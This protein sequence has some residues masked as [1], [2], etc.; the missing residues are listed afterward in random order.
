MKQ[1]V[2][3]LDILGT[4]ELVSRDEFSDSHAF[5]FS[6]AVAV[7][8]L[9]F[10]SA[11]FAA[12]S[13]CVIFSVPANSPNDIISIL[14]H[15]FENWLSDGIFVRGGISVGDIRWIDYQS[16]REFRGLKNLSFARVY[17]KALSEAVDIERS[18]G[19][20]ILP[21]A[22]DA[23]ADRLSNRTEDSVLRLSSN[24]LRSFEW[25]NLDAWIRTMD[26]YL[27]YAE[28]VQARRHI[29]ATKRVLEI[30]KL[31]NTEQGGKGVDGKKLNIGK[32]PK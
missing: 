1:F 14:C 8:A 12:F 28:S 22:S 32:R 3:Y 21:F 9:R 31:T 27:K 17:G 24:I 29:R 20:G 19:P 2:A 15:L 13:D 5:D 7:A 16:D 25:A 11:R 6:G 26:I 10:R 4:K 18:S 30:F 23:V